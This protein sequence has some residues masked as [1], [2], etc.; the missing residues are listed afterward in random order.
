MGERYLDTIY[1]TNWVEGI[2]GS[3]TLSTDTLNNDADTLVAA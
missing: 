2:Y 3:D 1:N